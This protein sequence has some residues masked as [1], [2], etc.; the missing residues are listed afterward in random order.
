MN[1]DS[2]SDTLTIYDLRFP[3]IDST[4]IEH[5][6]F[7]DLMSD[8]TILVYF[9]EPIN[10]NSF[11]YELKSKL[12]VSGFNH[13]ISLSPD[14]LTILLDSTIMSYDTLELNI[15]SIEGVAELRIIGHLE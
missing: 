3:T 14:S 8:S 9:S 11:S 5:E 12:D 7:I 15:V 4:S 2:S 13:T 6:G 10:T 1:A